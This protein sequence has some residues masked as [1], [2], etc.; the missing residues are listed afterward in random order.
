[1]NHSRRGNCLILIIAILLLVWLTC[2]GGCALIK[3]K[4]ADGLR[5]DP[6][7]T[8]PVAVPVKHVT[9]EKK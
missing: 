9:P 2:W 7:S 5:D 4:T 6:V 1:M 8:Q 3:K